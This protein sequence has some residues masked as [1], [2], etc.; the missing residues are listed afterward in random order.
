[1]DEGQISSRLRADD[2]DSS[3]SS[4]SSGIGV[5]QLIAENIDR[6]QLMSD[7]ELVADSEE[8]DGGKSNGFSD[9]DEAGNNDDESHK[10]EHGESLGNIVTRWLDAYTRLQLDDDYTTD[11][12]VEI[13]R[14]AGDNRWTASSVDELCSSLAHRVLPLACKMAGHD[15]GSAEIDVTFPDSYDKAVGYLKQFIVSPTEVY[16]C[17]KINCDHMWTDYGKWKADKKCPSC[18]HH[19]NYTNSK[20]STLR[21]FPLAETLRQIYLHPVL[22]QYM[23]SHNT[24]EPAPEGTYRSI[25]G[26]Y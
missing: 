17:E 22:S 1:M 15:L 9:V 12:V 21:Y 7:S 4:A 18:D 5:D 13:L 26:A 8:S 23:R 6:M 2:D 10:L 25:W 20:A 11:M 24:Y 19:I 14:C 3:A 16:F